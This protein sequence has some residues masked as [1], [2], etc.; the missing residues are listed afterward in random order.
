MLQS[1]QHL[2]TIADH[3]FQSLECVPTIGQ[4]LKEAYNRN[5]DLSQKDIAL[6][7]GLSTT[8]INRI[9]NGQIRKPS[10]DKL[11]KLAP[12]I[13]E[14]F[15]NLLSYSGYSNLNSGLSFLNTKGEEIDYIKAV[16][17]IYKMD[18]ELLEIFS[19]LNIDLDK[20]DIDILKMYLRL[21]SIEKQKALKKTALY[22]TFIELFKT[23][24][25]FIFKEFQSIL[26]LLET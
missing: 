4:K 25:I 8:D 19:T 23:I 15:Q 14:P 11:K 2:K 7:T 16:F 26:T 5:P 20:M 10:K 18:W 13:G 9:L 24:K 21:V 12:F 22:T 1:N 17:Y 3:E 6:Y